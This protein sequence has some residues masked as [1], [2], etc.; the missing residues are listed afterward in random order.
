[1]KRLELV[2]E[3]DDGQDR[4]L[5]SVEL[6]QERWHNDT[7]EKVADFSVERQEL[8]A[9]H[10]SDMQLLGFRFVIRII[11]IITVL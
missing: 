5:K 2:Q 4:I 9:Y 7:M 11:K 3:T 10:G 1:M 8:E 6:T